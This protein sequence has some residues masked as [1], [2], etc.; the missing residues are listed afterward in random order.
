MKADGAFQKTRQSGS[1]EA[2]KEVAE[3][4]RQCFSLFNDEM[5]RLAPGLKRDIQQAL[6]RAEAWGMQAEMGDHER[7]GTRI[8]QL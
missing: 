4:Y 8:K 3:A 5:S 1:V 6:D 2:A 7:V